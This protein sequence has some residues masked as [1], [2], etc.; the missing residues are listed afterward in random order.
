MKGILTILAISLFASAEA[1]AGFQI[2]NTNITNLRVRHTVAYI[3]FT[4]CARYAR[5]Y[6]DTEYAKAMYTTALTAAVSGK[7]VDVEFEE[8]SCDVEPEI[9]YLDINI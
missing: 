5:V 1:L 2:G 4:H 8:D 9:K 6:L 7:Q 3:K